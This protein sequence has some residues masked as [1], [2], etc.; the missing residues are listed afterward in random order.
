MTRG[1]ALRALRRFTE[2]SGDASLE[3][4]Q[5]C[6]GTLS[7]DHAHRLMAVRRQ[8]ECLCD[9]CAFEMPHESPW[10]VVAHKVERL[11]GF[12]MTAVEWDS[13]GLPVRLAFFV[14]R[15]DGDGAR[16][17]FPSAA[18]ATEASLDADRWRELR[19]KSPRLSKMEPNVEALL[20][21]HAAG[22][23]LAFLVSI[24][25]CYALVGTLRTHWRGFA[26]GPEAW[27][28]LDAFMSKLTGM[29]P[30]HAEAQARAH[31]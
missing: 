21:H 20:V 23:Q 18:G 26:G 13:L 4:C 9:K 22:R 12:V 30:V 2:D 27:Q 6:M 25:V 14:R 10:Q 17:F 15:P 29:A 7:A 1:A 31:A 3:R 24:D 5:R 11:P 8:L 16:A 28:A 19:D